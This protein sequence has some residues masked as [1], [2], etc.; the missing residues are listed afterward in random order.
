MRLLINVLWKTGSLPSATV[1][2]VTEEHHP[3]TPKK[4]RKER[5][6]RRRRKRKREKTP[7]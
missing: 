1:L 5:R 2:M 6:R 7:G 3:R 4:E